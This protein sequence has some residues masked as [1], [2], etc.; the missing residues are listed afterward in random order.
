M[1]TAIFSITSLLALTPAF[2][3]VSWVKTSFWQAP[4]SDNQSLK[5]Q[6]F[7]KEL[8]DECKHFDSIAWNSKG[9]VQI[10]KPDQIQTFR[11]M[12][13]ESDMSETFKVEL[14]LSAEP[15]ADLSGYVN[16]TAK[17]DIFTNFT[18]NSSQIVLR[19]ESLGQVVITNDAKSLSAISEKFNLSPMPARVILNGNDL[20]LHLE[21]KDLACDLLAKRAKLSVQAKVQV[22]IPLENQLTIQK[23]NAEI[24]KISDEVLAKAKTPKVRA[25][26]LGFYLGQHFAKANDHNTE[27]QIVQMLSQFY[28]DDSLDAITNWS[29]TG[30]SNITDQTLLID[31][32]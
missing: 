3:G 14:P 30:T 18:Q 24:E 29:V 26:L 11:T 32:E 20:Y 4:Y 8:Q 2:A 9:V 21:G 16:E 23:Q 19:P 5:I 22:K 10:W 25:A 6:N 15:Q 17:S 12:P 7:P 27:A 31:G 13:L 1:K 28:R